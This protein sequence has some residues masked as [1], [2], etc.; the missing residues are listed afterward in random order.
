MSYFKV[1]F[2]ILGSLHFR[3]NFI[4]SLSLISHTHIHTNV[5]AVGILIGVS[6][7]IKIKLERMDILK[8]L[9][10]P[11]NGEHMSL[12]LTHLL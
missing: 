4:A 10:F 6:L 2:I 1:V 3:M 7:I 11:N 9:S 8:I 12:H 5:H